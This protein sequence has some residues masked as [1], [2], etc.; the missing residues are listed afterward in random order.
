MYLPI[1]FHECSRWQALFQ[2]VMQ[3]EDPAYRIQIIPV[4]DSSCVMVANVDG[5]SG[6]AFT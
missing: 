6:R 1:R 2:F 3:P 5:V 4:R